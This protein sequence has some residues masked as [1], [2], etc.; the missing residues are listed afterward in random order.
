MTQ[1]ESKGGGETETLFQLPSLLLGSLMK[2]CFRGQ[3]GKARAAFQDLKSDIYTNDYERFSCL[4][5]EGKKEGVRMGAGMAEKC[6]SRMSG[7]IW[8]LK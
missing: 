4:N 1:I 3:R 7:Y 2:R 6:D 5:S 8:H